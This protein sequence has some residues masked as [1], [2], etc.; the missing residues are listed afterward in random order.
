MSARSQNKMSDCTTFA[1]VLVVLIIAAAIAYWYFYRGESFC[2]C[3]GMGVQID[4][5]TNTFWRGAWPRSFS[6]TP[7]NSTSPY[8]TYPKGCGSPSFGWPQM[9]GTPFASKMP[10]TSPA[11]MYQVTAP[12]A[13]YEMGPNEMRDIIRDAQ[14]GLLNDVA[15]QQTFGQLVPTVNMQSMPMMM[16]GSNGSTSVRQTQMPLSY[17]MPKASMMPQALANTP[18]MMMNGGCDGSSMMSAA[19]LR[20]QQQASQG[21]CSMSAASLSKM[22][23]MGVGGSNCSVQFPTYSSSD[24][25]ACG[26]DSTS[27]AVPRFVSL[28]SIQGATLPPGA[29]TAACPCMSAVANRMR[30]GDAGYGSVAVGVA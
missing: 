11:A 4:R 9:A 26:G 20:Q 18:M 6:V 22:M 15:V 5:P 28:S 3:T 1:I 24:C 21:M 8:G 10:C 23:P 25:C 2:N 14:D 16:N 27:L 30:F 12:T 7:L 19:Q 29:V 17:S 13:P